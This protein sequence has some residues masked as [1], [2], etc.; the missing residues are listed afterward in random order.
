MFVE[1]RT[2]GTSRAMDRALLVLDLDETLIYARDALDRHGYSFQVARYYVSVRPH[3]S[4]FLE[5][6]FDWFSVAVWTSAG[7]DYGQQVIAEVFPNPKALEFS[8][9]ANR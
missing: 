3:L 2:A 6:V 7:E 4:E 5:S 8:W 1:Q 9:F